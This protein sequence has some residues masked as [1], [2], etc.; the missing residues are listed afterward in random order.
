MTTIALPTSPA[1]NGAQPLLRDFGGVLT[2]F[3]GGPEQRINRVGTRF[4]LRVTLPPMRS[5]DAGRIY[6]S[7][8]LR[9][10]Q[11][12]VLM[13]WHLLDFSP[14]N[15]GAPKVSAA[16]SGGMSLPVKGL[17]AGYT[18]REGQFF[19]IVHGGARVMHMASADGT[20]D[21]SGNLTISIYPP[22]RVALA[23]NDVIEMAQPM[24]EGLVSPG[25]EL[26]WDM[27]INRHIGL[28]FS[29]MEAE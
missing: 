14:G 4:G 16:T 3:L 12:R 22:L 27:S 9:G 26:G 13:R 15:P 18:V 28:S 17:T 25:D 8:L 11:D 2:P 1:P 6:V 23:I 7:R 21:G 24:I 29:V 20:A 19:S 5:A 10:R